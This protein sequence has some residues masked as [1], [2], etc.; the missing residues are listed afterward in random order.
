MEEI[1]NKVFPNAHEE[2]VI[3]DDFAI[4]LAQILC[5]HMT[6]FKDTFADVIDWH[7]SHRYSAEMS[8][9]SDVVN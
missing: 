4:L 8:T 3:H 6:Y 7:I 5:S 2:S 9:K 1:I